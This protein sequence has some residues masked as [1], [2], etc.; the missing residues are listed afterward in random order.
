MKPITKPAIFVRTAAMILVAAFAMPA[1]TQKQV[2]FKGA[3][4]AKDCTP[5]DNTGCSSLNSATV[6]TSRTR[7]ATH[8][9]EFS[10]TQQTDLNTL[11]GSAH[12]VATHSGDRLDSTFTVL[13]F[14]QNTPP[15][16]NTITEMHTITGGT[17]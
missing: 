14:Q 5:I 16:H 9:G 15:G 4:Q 13:S 11:N 7:I 6:E 1:A 17:G 3:F 8:M 2:P 10:F 12:F